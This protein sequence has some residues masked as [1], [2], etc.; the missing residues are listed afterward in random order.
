MAR[1][2]GVNI[3]T[4]KRVEIG[5][6]YIHGIGPHVARNIITQ[7]GIARTFQNSRLFAEMTALEN[8]MV[9][10]SVHHHTT[11]PE[12]LLSV[13]GEGTIRW[14]N[15]AAERTFGG[16][17]SDIVG[18]PLADFVPLSGSNSNHSFNRSAEDCVTSFAIR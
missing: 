13:T 18:R 6:R 17:L 9:A 8:V 2:A 7:L 10:A 14:C 11:L 12:A 1:I 5:L 15:A 3:P 4:Q 16:G